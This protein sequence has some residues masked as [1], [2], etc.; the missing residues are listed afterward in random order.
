MVDRL[1]E[2]KGTSETKDTRFRVL[3]RVRLKSQQKP[4][5]RFPV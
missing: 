1:I 5:S 2:A 4:E 3:S